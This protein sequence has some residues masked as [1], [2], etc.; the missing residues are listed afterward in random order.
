VRRLGAPPWPCGEKRWLYR[1]YTSKEGVGSAEA[2]RQRG[3]AAAAESRSTRGSGRGISRS[4]SAVSGSSPAAKRRE[5]PFLT[6]RDR[7]RSEL[8]HREC[9][10]L[11][12][13]VR[14]GTEIHLNF[15]TYTGA[16]KGSA[17]I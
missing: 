9:E 14:Y 4:G 13:A 8:L 7:F 16:I 3:V 12:A 15:S 5:S 6:K 1:F 17:Y 11:K 10:E 2:G